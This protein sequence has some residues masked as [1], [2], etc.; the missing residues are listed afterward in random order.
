VAPSNF[1]NT[2]RLSR[3]APLAILDPATDKD[4]YVLPVTRISAFPPF[5]S[6]IPI[7]HFRLTF[8]R[9]SKHFLL[10]SLK[11]LSKT[12]DSLSILTSVQPLCFLFFFFVFPFK[13]W[14]L[15]RR[16][17]TYLGFTNV[18]VIICT[19]L[20]LNTYCISNRIRF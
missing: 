20:I 4:F 18:R 11:T 9:L 16:L 5:P 17:F 10:L 3:D 13:Y 2:L 7:L 15:G 12:H 8:A 14:N 19:I 6:T 1:A